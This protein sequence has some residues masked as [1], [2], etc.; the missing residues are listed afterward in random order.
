MTAAQWCLENPLRHR[1]RRRPAKFLVRRRDDPWQPRPPVARDHKL[2]QRLALRPAR[3]LQRRGIGGG[4]RYNARQLLIE[5]TGA[6]IL[7]ARARCTS[8]V[9]SSAVAPSLAASNGTAAISSLLHGSAGP[10]RPSVIAG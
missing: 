4:T 3:R 5:T 6:P 8:S 1:R 9:D 7:P 2:D 10:L